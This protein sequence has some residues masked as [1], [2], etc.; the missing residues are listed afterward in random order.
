M[1]EDPAEDPISAEDPFEG[2]RAALFPKPDLV[3]PRMPD[4]EL[5]KFIQ[6]MLA[7]QIFVSE[8][9]RNPADV[10]MVFMPLLLGALGDYDPRSYSDIGVFYE[11][12]SKSLPRSINGY[13]CFTSVRM[14]HRLD[15]IRARK[16][17]IAEQERL[18]EIPLPPDE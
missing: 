3:L 16:A 15:W 7:N 18:K 6:D 12:H 2:D 13:P 11:Y 8:Q 10:G 5:R 4:D 1:N 14:L 9:V 17:I